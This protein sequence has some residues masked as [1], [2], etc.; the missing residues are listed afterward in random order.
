[1]FCRDLLSSFL[2]KLSVF[3]LSY[4]ELIHVKFKVGNSPKVNE[5]LKRS[6]DDCLQSS[7]RLLVIE[8]K[9][10]NLERDFKQLVVELIAP[11]QILES[12]GSNYLYGDISLGGI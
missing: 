3:P 12:S 8:A 4:G 9:D 11:D 7:T 1:M 10:K 6:P 5:L 2:Y